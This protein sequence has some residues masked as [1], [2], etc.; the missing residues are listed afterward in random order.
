MAIE[1][2]NS[3]LSGIN[4]L[5]L[6]GTTE[7][8]DYIEH[9][10]DADNEF[11]RLSVFSAKDFVEAS[12]I[13]KSKDIDVVFLEDGFS[14]KDYVFMLNE[15]SKRDSFIDVF[16]YVK[17]PDL[18]KIREAMRIGNVRDYLDAPFARDYDSF[19]KQLLVYIRNKNMLVSS[20]LEECNKLGH[21]IDRF[22]SATFDKGVAAQIVNNSSKV[23]DISKKDLSLCLGFVQIYNEDFELRD[24]QQ[25]LDPAHKKIIELA[26]ELGSKKMNK[27][28]TSV[29]AFVVT[30]ACRLASLLAQGLSIPEVLEKVKKDKSPY[31]KH[32]A[33][34]R[35]TNENLNMLVLKKIGE[36][37]AG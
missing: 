26:S 6:A 16:V 30:L 29:R 25:L 11:S 32:R 9:M 12:S 19:K 20:D 2:L 31:F 36:R 22:G 33:L 14:G 1:L 15:I 21:L 23:F 37:R 27:A 13:L 35:L 5:V 10:A 17:I 4:V 18:N 28:P 7:D 24:Y 34:L 8:W 3:D